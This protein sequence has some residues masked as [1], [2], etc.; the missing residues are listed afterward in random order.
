MTNLVYEIDGNGISLSHVYFNVVPTIPPIVNP[1]PPPV[2]PGIG[3]TGATGAIGAT[4][5]TGA[6]GA[7]GPAGPTGLTGATGPAG[8]VGP[9]GLTGATPTIDYPYIVAQ[10]LLAMA[11]NKILTSISISG[12]NSLIGGNPANY[13][14]T[15]TYNNGVPVANVSPVIWSVP[16]GL[17]TINS[18]G[19][20]T[21][22][23]TLT[24]VNGNVSASYTENGVTLNTTLALTELPVPPSPVYPYYG[25]GLSNAVKNA[26]LITALPGRGLVGDLTSTF[27][28]TDDS[29]HSMYYAYPA[30]YGLAQFENQ[31]AIGFFG[32]W[33]AAT[34][35]PLAGASGPLTINVMVN[36]VSTPFYLYETDFA[37]IGTIT[38]K[39]TH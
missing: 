38:W 19:V 25:I 3:A 39:V 26:A 32:G 37:N 2:I 4:G 11:V 9:T 22:G 29:T 33:D 7:T 16:V 14:L 24:N 31:A 34:G 8:P 15:A 23:V 36:G 27:T 28:L 20:L 30:S 35:D 10:T 18:S 12:P 13:T 21:T 5:T 1:P 6:T 17:G